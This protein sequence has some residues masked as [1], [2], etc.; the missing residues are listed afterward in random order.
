[1]FDLVEKGE[2]SHAELGAHVERI[3]SLRTELADLE[4]GQGESENPSS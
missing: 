2:L 3:R 1:V 4:A